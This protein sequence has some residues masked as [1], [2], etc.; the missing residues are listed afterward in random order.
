[1]SSEGDR[2]LVVGTAGHVDHGK[3]A[4]VRALTG[5]D[6]DRLEVERRRGM[7]IELGF[8]AWRLP[9]GREVSLVDVPG[10]ER[11]VG[12]MA[13]GARSVDLALF[14][15]AVDDGVMPQTREHAAILAL[16][17]VAEAVVVVTKV[18]LDPDGAA[19]V[20]GQALGLLAEVGVPAAGWLGVSVPTGQGLVPLARMADRHLDR[21][22]PPVDRGLPRLLVDRSFSVAG[23]GTVVT[24][25]LTGGGLQVG[26]LVEIFPTGARGRISGMQRRGGRVQGARPGGRLALALRGLS[27]PE[28]PRGSAVT[29]AGRAGPSERL[30]CLVQVPAQGASGL[31]QGMRLQVLGCPGTVPALLWLAGEQRVQPGHAAYCQLVLQRPGWA[32][33]GDRLLLR[34]PSPAAT[35]A[36]ATVLDAQ[37]PPH[38]RWVRAPVELWSARQR[39]LLEAG[40]EAPLGLAEVEL[41]RCPL[42]ASAE[43]LARRI[44]ARPEELGGHLRGR[45]GLGAVVQA[46]SRF[47]SLSAWQ[48]LCAG[49][50][51]RLA[52]YQRRRPLEGTM[53]RAAL[54]SA[55]RLGGGREGEAVLE[56]MAAWGAIDLGEGRAALPGSGAHG[57]ATPAAIRVLRLLEAGGSAA[58]GAGQLRLAGATP[59][60][61]A[62]LEREGRAVRL[63]PGLL[64]SSPVA[65]QLRQRLLE[66]LAATPEG[67][68]VS[69]LRGRLGTTR[70]VLIPLLERLARDRITER[71]G[72]LHRLRQESP[73]PP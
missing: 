31:R 29:L 51:A 16:L 52:A 28:A 6:T 34:A 17:E 66:L 42:G 73:C 32:L 14:C 61:A 35:L 37:P 39:A 33:P 68:S 7:S 27:P 2:E 8:A 23:A 15:V 53:P 20:A 46:G 22:E 5:V 9:S 56:R 30:D 54:L 44:G 26:D 55:L 67:L 63:G 65:A 24:G 70:R 40:A 45:A 47:W 60:I 72:D 25:A 10:H 71:Q 58:P 11:F 48:S 12:T 64:I 62:Y 36:G 69:T 3:T 59:A 19:R 21:L 4:L 57:H 1:M 13:L 49:A 38:R 18:D 50:S 43:Q 41:E